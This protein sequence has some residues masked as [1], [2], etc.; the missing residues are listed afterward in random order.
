VNR[1]CELL[2]GA[3]P[4]NSYFSEC[5]IVQRPRSI[6]KILSTYFP[7]PCNYHGYYSGR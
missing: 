7:K 4:L 5:R 3:L 6:S 1:F 2:L